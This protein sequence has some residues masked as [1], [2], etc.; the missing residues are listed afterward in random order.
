MCHK[1][2]RCPVIA[3]FVSM[4]AFY[5]TNSVPKITE[6]SRLIGGGLLDPDCLRRGRRGEINLYEKLANME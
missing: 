4:K 2:Y 6:R 1:D 3:V 5:L